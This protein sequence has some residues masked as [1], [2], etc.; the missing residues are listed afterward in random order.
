M[1]LLSPVQLGQISQRPSWKDLWELLPIL[2]LFPSFNDIVSHRVKIKL[3][4]I[5]YLYGILPKEVFIP[6]SRYRVPM[7]QLKSL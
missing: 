6:Y 5:T 2:S 1:D 3:Q 7:S 4:N